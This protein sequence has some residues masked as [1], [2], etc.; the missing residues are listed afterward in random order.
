MIA[1]TLPKRANPVARAAAAGWKPQSRRKRWEWCEDNCRAEPGSPLPGPW[2]SENSPQSRE[3]L[4][5]FGNNAVKDLAV[6]CSAQSSKTS[7]ILCA[8]QWAISEDPGPAMWVTS[9]QD[10]AE[11]DLR[12]RFGPTFQRC[13]PVREQIVQ[14]TVSDVQ[15]A[16][17]PLY[18]VGA[19]SNPKLQSKPIRW[20]ILDEVR[21]YPKGAVET[22]LKRTRSYWNS[23]RVLVSTP[24]VKDDAVHRAYLAGDQRVYHV[25]CPSCEQLQPLKWEQFVAENPDTGRVCKFADVPGA[26]VGEA[27]DFDRLAPAIRYQCVACGHLIADVPGV[28]KK[29]ANAGRF[30][31]TNPKAP[32]HRVSFHWNAIL[33]FLVPFRSIVEEF[34]LA[35]AAARGGDLEP[36]RAFV[37]E[38]LGE[39]WE[40]R[41]GEIDDYGFLDDRRE[42][43]ALADPWGEEWV[44]FMSADRQAAGGEHYFWVVRAFSRSGGSRLVAYGRCNSLLELEKQRALHGVSKQNCAIDSGFKASE[45]YRFCLSNGWKAFK[46]DKADFFLVQDQ[47][48]K[49]VIRR[50]WDISTVDAGLGV[51]GKGRRIVRQLPLYRWSNSAL[52]DKFGE[53]ATG[54]VPGWTLPANVERAF[55]KHLS[56]HVHEEQRDNLGRAK[57]VWRQRYADDHWL[58]CELQILVMA[59]ICRLAAEPQA[60][61]ASL[62]A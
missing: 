28:R 4:E 50:C 37:T 30:I 29:M 54:L 43:Y 51:H 42:D 19:G 34:L 38:T 27:W 24:G 21:N 39:P 6:M 14:Q 3:V 60:Q 25:P 35:Q 55:L 48:Q 44:R 17:M 1:D 41:L 12:D 53:L 45:V 23:R 7:T 8:I 57:Y 2:R 18:F 36:L 26:K 10:Q 22:V 61:E 16:T 32:R 31:R 33:N 59:I 62:A 52:R 15:F 47:A 56:A 46:G 40:D 13:A 5:E 11:E 49:K 58:D 9:N 20:L